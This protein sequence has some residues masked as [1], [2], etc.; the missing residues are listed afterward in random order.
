MSKFQQYESDIYALR[1]MLA[2]ACK[3]ATNGTPKSSRTLVDE[4]AAEYEDI[5]KNLDLAIIKI[6]KAFKCK[7]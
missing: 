4:L 7:D 5:K 3:I 1:Y 2:E 6:N